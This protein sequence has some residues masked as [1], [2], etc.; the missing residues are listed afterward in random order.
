M[1]TWLDETVGQLVRGLEERGL[2]DD[3]LF[4]FVC[5]NGW[6]QRK[7]RGGFAPR[8]KRSPYDGGLRTPIVIRWKG[9]VEP[10]RVNKPVMSTDIVSTLLAALGLEIPE[11][12]G[13]DLLNADAV[14]RRGPLLSAVFG[15]NAVDILDLGRSDDPR[16]IKVALLARTRPD[17]DSAIGQIEVACARISL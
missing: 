7:N 10:G 5:D 8:S 4:V 13:I 15:H 2:A 16:N 6:I 11:G 9:R 12:L 1:C 14:A 3:T 17:A